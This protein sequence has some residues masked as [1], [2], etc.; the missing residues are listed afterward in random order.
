MYTLAPLIVMWVLISGG[1][2]WVNKL[3][4]APVEQ[5]GYGFPFVTLL[6]LWHMSIVI[7][8]TNLIR[9]S[10]PDLMPAAAKNEISITKYIRSILPVG[11]CLA[12][13]L[14]LSNAAYIHISVGYIQMVKS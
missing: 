4:F 13:S 6:M 11:I 2:T 3:I 10:Q 8:F 7:L 1:L 5:G 9:F 14:T 12:G